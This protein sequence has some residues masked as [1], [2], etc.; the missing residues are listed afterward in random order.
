MDACGN[1]Y[2][3]YIISSSHAYQK[4]FK[5]KGKKGS[6]EKQTDCR[7]SRMHHELQPRPLDQALHVGDLLREGGA[8]GADLERLYE[9][10]LDDMHILDRYG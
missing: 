2:F 4:R 8:L 3:M 7:T 1:I 5:K 9:V 6:R 10:R